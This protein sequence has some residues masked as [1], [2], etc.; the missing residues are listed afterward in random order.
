MALRFEHWQVEGV[1]SVLRLE[2]GGYLTDP[3]FVDCFPDSLVAIEAAWLLTGEPGTAEG[4]WSA[5]AERALGSP[6]RGQLPRAAV[7]LVGAANL[8]TLD[9]AW[10]DPAPGSSLSM[11]SIELPPNAAVDAPLSEASEMLS[12]AETQQWLL[13]SVAGEAAGSGGESD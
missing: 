12:G 5:L 6:P 9:L 7:R 2:D 8:D 1:G 3:G 13:L 10:L 4:D 11:A